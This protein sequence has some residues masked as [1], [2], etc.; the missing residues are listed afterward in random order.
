MLGAGAGAEAGALSGLRVEGV[1]FDDDEEEVREEVSTPTIQ[2]M[3]SE[4][5]IASF[6]DD[7]DDDTVRM[8]L[9]TTDLDDD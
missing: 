1:G 5:D 8:E 4:E 9:G 3:A 2:E 7:D 6:D